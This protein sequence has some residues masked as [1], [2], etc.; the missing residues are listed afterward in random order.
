MKNKNKTK[1]INSNILILS[2]ITFLLVLLISLACFIKNNNT[3]VKHKK[4]DLEKLEK[5]IIKKGDMLVSSINNIGLPKKES[6]TIIRELKKVI[7]INYC[8]PGDFYEISYNEKTGKWTNFKYC[9]KGI[10]Y[11]SIVKFPNNTIK[12]EKKTY[13]ITTTTYEKQGSISSSLW[14][15]M[16]S[17]NIP[18]NIIVLF[19]DIFAWQ[20]DFLTNT[21]KNDS[22]IVVY[23]IKKIG[24][25]NKIYSSN[26]I[27]AQY[28]KGTKIYNAFYFKTKDGLSGYFDENGKYLKKTFLKAPLQFSRI[29]SVFTK[30]RMHPILKRVKPHLGIDYAAPSG[31]PVSSIGDGVIIKAKYSGGFGNMVVI[32]HKNGYETYYSHLS[33]YAK[34]IKNGVFVKQGQIIGYVGMTGLATGPHLDFR[35][36]FNNE[37]FDFLKM[38]QKFIKTLDSNEIKK[39]EEKIHPFIKK[40]KQIY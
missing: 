26:I 36:K 15:S 17:Q 13:E 4:Y 31:T 10:L 40:F 3:N 32:N 11:Y 22:F 37:F 23:N 5:V 24:K 6:N 39:F 14:S 9:P 18:P 2:I 29:S 34:S 7:N 21:K 30:H 35:I 16:S 8:L 38:K 27:A 25:K 20:I 33:K 28:K 1:H 12:T 19:A